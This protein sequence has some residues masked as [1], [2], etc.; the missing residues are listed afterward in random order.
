MSDI[1]QLEDRI[2]SALDRIRRGLE[3][4]SHDRPDV[5]SGSES[6]GDLWPSDPEDRAGAGSAGDSEALTAKLAAA[7]RDA[8]ELRK[9]LDEER[10]A[11]KYLEDRVL[12]LK[13]RQDEQI[14][15][16]NRTIDDLRGGFSAFEGKIDDLRAANAKLQEQ[17]DRLRKAAAEDSVDA[18][19]INAAMQAEIDS[20]R[21]E[22]ALDA[23][24][25]DA[26]LRLLEPVVK[27]AK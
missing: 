16:L 14:A 3:K 26:I 7:E 1:S 23:G 21:A 8:G 12:A 15:D 22:R 13:A 18:G 27:E 25:M 20:L 5:G 2:T 9:K 4:L 6:R 19:L 17:S 10:Q 24:E 11:T